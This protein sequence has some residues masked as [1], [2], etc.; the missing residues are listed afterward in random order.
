MLPVSP[1]YFQGGFDPTN[2]WSGVDSRNNTFVRTL[3]T[4]CSTNVLANL[5][6]STQLVLHLQNQNVCLTFSFWLLNI[7]NLPFQPSSHA[8]LGWLHLFLHLF[9]INYPLLQPIP[10]FLGLIVHTQG[11]GKVWDPET[12][13]QTDR[14]TE[15]QKETECKSFHSEGP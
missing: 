6:N 11:G 13:R 10:A 5:V 15:R 2:F 12:D 1:N 9:G 3:L 4:W 14:Q 8:I 7:S